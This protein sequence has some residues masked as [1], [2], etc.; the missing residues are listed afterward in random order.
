MDI[1]KTESIYSETLT[2]ADVLPKVIVAI[3]ILYFLEVNN[4]AAFSAASWTDSFNDI[5]CGMRLTSFTSAFRSDARRDI[6][7]VRLRLTRSSF[8]F[9]LTNLSSTPLLFAAITS[10]DLKYSL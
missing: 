5:F 4:S 6:A 10:K 1:P 2:G 9:E 8:G 7:S 3:N